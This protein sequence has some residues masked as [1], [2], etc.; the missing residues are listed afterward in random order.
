MKKYRRN[1]INGFLQAHFEEPE[2]FTPLQQLFFQ[3]LNEVLSDSTESRNYMEWLF[4]AGDTAREGEITLDEFSNFLRALEQDGIC[5]TLFLA[6]ASPSSL[7][8]ALPETTAT[9]VGRTELLLQ[10]PPSHD[11]ASW[12]S[13]LDSVKSVAAVL[14]EEFD[15][16]GNK[17]MA[18]A[19]F[20]PFAK[21]VV[22]EF[23]AL[24]RLKRYSAKPIPKL[25]I[26]RTL[27]VGGEC[28]VRL[29]LLAGATPVSVSFFPNTREAILRLERSRILLKRLEGLPVQQT[30][31]THFQPHCFALVKELCSC[32]VEDM[33]LEGNVTEPI[34]RRI[35]RELAQAFRSMHRAEVAHRD[36]SP[37]NILVSRTGEVRIADFGISMVVEH[38]FGAQTLISPKHQLYISGNPYSVA[39]EV[40]C[41]K[42]VDPFADDVWQLGVLLFFMLSGRYPFLPAVIGDDKSQA[43]RQLPPDGD[44]LA[45]DALRFCSTMLR[46]DPEA[47]PS[48]TAVLADPWLS[49]A[50]ARPV[51]ARKQLPFAR[52]DDAE[53]T[54]LRL[55]PDLQRRDSDEMCYTP[56]NITFV[57]A[58]R[59]EGTELQLIEGFTWNFRRFVH[60]A[61]VRA[62]AVK[63]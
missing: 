13:E 49:G 25:E 36:I 38:H 53:C 16:T 9:E 41:G 50:T 6:E 15:L 31:C 18:F 44:G 59:S 39:P 17:R 3:R 32:S 23:R 29:G 30:L 11:E 57:C 20:L 1:P 2:Y 56:L 47:R 4:R 58:D 14:M 37:Q 28:V 51:L 42:S 61:C 7:R 8:Q 55:F 35:F 62:A 22:N 34:A 24:W 45:P 21:L 46:T 12:D 33:V 52:R 26:R 40:L 19:E 54:L 63:A 27:G 48:L 60:A 5:P 43:Q 10:F